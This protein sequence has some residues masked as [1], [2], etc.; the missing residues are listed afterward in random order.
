MS[1]EAGALGRAEAQRVGRMLDY[2]V[3]VSR[4]QDLY[5]SSV[6]E[7]AEPRLLEFVRDGNPIYAWPFEK[8]QVWRSP[9]MPFAA[10]ALSRMTAANRRGAR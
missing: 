8:R 3:I 2:A 10:R 4:L 9:N 5:E 1:Q 7:L 6:Q